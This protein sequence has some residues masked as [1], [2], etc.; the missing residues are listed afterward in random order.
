M[1][2]CDGSH[3]VHENDDDIV[4]KNEHIDVKNENICNF[5]TLCVD[6]K[7]NLRCAINAE[8]LL[9]YM[10]QSLSETLVWD[11]YT[12]YANAYYTI[13]TSNH[14]DV[15]LGSSTRT[16]S[17]IFDQSLS[18]DS[19]KQTAS[20]QPILCSKANRMNKRYYLQLNGYQRMLILGMTILALINLPDIVLMENY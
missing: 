18:Q 20:L 11:Y 9:N 5:N 13:D 14:T 12:S 19:A 6:Q 3:I 17:K 8:Y 4:R 1:S 10:H 7:T 15:T 2:I 16:V